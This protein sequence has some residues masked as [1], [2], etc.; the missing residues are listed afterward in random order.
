MH[1][2]TLVGLFGCALAPMVSAPVRRHILDSTMKVMYWVGAGCAYVRARGVAGATIL[3]Y[4]S[5]PDARMARWIDPANA[6][7]PS[8]FERQMRFLRSRRRVVSLSRLVARLREGVS[9]EPG[10]V[11]LTFD[12]GYRDNFEVA[13]PILRRYDLPATLYAPTGIVTRGESPWID[14]L[15][16]TFHSRSAQRLELPGGDAAAFD[17]SHRGQALAAYSAVRSRLTQVTPGEREEILRDVRDQLRPSER[18]PRLTMTWEDLRHLV[19]DYPEIEIGGHTADHLDL[20]S[21]DGQTA[22]KQIDQCITDI[23]R[24]LGFRPAHFA[25]PYSRWNLETRQ[26]VI[27]S[28]FVSAVGAGTDYLISSSSDRFALPRIDPPR[29]MTLFRFHTSGAYPGLPKRLMGRA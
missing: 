25:F 16:T 11:V 7:P 3:M 9:P 15:Y 26:M 8:L 6:V 13:A 20:G 29:S 21:T 12:D 23:K 28:G 17:L 27:R 24:E 18:P 19:R 2:A 10:T 22:Q 1:L 4:H 5:V 14:E